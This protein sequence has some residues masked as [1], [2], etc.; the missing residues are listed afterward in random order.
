MAT[1]GRI[2][3][4]AVVLGALGGTGRAQPVE[5]RIAIVDATDAPAGERV[6]TRL[7]H[8]LRREPDLEAIP[9][10]D[11]ARALEERPSSRPDLGRLPE[12]E[13]E[14]AAGRDALDRFQT[15]KALVHLAQAER[16]VLASAVTG[17]AVAVLG[18]IRF[19]IGLAHLRDQNRGLA[20]ASFALAVRHAPALGKPDPAR[21]PPD[22]VAP[23]AAAA[24]ARPRARVALTVSTTFDGAAVVVDGGAVG[25][26]PWHG[27][28]EAG[29]HAV[30][31]GSRVHVPDGRLV[32][33]DD[34]PVAL[35]LDLQPLP[36]VDQARVLR[37]ALIAARDVAAVREGLAAI[38][39]LAGVDAALIVRDGGGS[40]AVYDR[41]RER[42]SLARP[43]ADADGLFGLLAPAELPGPLDLRVVA[44][45][46]PRP[47]WY[48]RPTGIAGIA[49][50]VGVAAVAT[51]LL[52]SGG[53][54]D[55]MPRSGTPVP[56][57]GAR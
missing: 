7:R 29:L 35:R 22:V 48:A 32:E 5:R 4:A 44:P 19:S 25:V 28:I 45:S 16:L 11:L 9:P 52:V 23:V 41:A 31:V 46:A 53:A 39:S 40:V 34:E 47:P 20:D 24:R 57:G 13:A 15:R 21:Y 12:A 43:P 49:A 55:P 18:E 14:L 37:A 56:L 3:T 17:P 2:L 6:A 51:F 33:V 8:A 30:Q 42:L 1:V 38:T 54:D 10:G 27:E 50:G 26:T 36:I